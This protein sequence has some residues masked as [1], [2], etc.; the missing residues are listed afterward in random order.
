MMT[1]FYKKRWEI[2]FDYLS[3]RLQGHEA[4]VPDFFQWERNWAAG[5]ERIEK[6]V[7][8]LSAAQII[9]GVL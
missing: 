8:V 6:Q 9:R 2:Y 1:S 4:T 5:H 3:Q 7:T